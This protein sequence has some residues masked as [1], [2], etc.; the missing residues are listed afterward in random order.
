MIREKEMDDDD[1]LSHRLIQLSVQCWI[2]LNHR[3]RVLRTYRHYLLC[4]DDMNILLNVININIDSTLFPKM[5]RS[6][7]FSHTFGKC[8]ENL[9]CSYIS[10]EKSCSN[11]PARSCHILN[12]G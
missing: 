6:V 12:V 3:D 4:F 5:A 11:C 8:F 9:K 7:D 1:L 2:Y 10:W